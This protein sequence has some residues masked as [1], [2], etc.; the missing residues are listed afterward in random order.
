MFYIGRNFQ[1]R[2]P[3]LNISDLEMIKQV[4]IKDFSKFTNKRVWFDEDNELASNLLGITDD[5]WKHV[6]STLTPTFTSGKLKQVS[7]ID[8]FQV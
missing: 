7:S 6:R 4:T 8:Q 5:H 1:G 2:S 3:L